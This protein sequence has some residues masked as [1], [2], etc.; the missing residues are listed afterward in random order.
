MIIT[1]GQRLQD[2][3]ESYKQS[4]EVQVEEPAISNALTEEDAVWEKLQ[5]LFS[6]VAERQN[7]VQKLQVSTGSKWL[8][9]LIGI[10]VRLCKPS[11]IV[12]MFSEILV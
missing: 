12:M 6:E 7:L 11:C 8:Y 9:L 5:K 3:L 1:A 4:K 10:V 2:Y